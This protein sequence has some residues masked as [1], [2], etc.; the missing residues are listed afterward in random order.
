MENNIYYHITSI[1]KMNVGDVLHFENEYNNFYN[2]LISIK[3]F[4]NNKNDANEIMTDLFS[5]KKL[6]FDSIS[7]FK[8][9]YN[10]VSDD[11][12]ILRE[13]IFEEVRKKYYPNCP[14]RFKCMFILKT[15]EEVDEWLNIFKRTKNKPLQI[16]KL[17]LDGN[18]FL[19]NANFI[20]RKNN[21]IIDKIS[22]AKSYWSG[23]KTKLIPE[24]LFLGTATVIEVMNIDE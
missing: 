17:K 5:K 1:K 16:V 6:T 24:Y 22:A 14:S 23:D 12:F 11:S 8:T 7:D 10:T 9:V 15:K 20:L 2:E 18:V 3:H 21:S 4:N 13:L 19:G